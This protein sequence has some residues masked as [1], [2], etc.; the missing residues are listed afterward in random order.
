MDTS[1]SAIYRLQA[2]NTAV[3][4]ENRIHDDETARRFGFR[5]GLVPGVEV[6]AYMAHMPVE[7]FG[8]A[9][10]ERGGMECRFLK[11]VYD[12]HV[13]MVSS[14]ADA[15][16][17]SLRVESDG[18]LCAKGQAWLREPQGARP[19]P[20]AVPGGKPPLE[21]AE[22]SETSLAPGT[23]LAIEPVVID[24]GML[25]QYLSDIREREPLYARAKLV[26]P[27]QILRLANLALLQNVRLGP[28]IHVGSRVENFAPARLHD[29]LS[30]HARIT[31]NYKH[32]GHA[33]VELDAAVLANRNA[34]IAQIRH[35]A[36][37]RPRQIEEA[38]VER[39]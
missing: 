37:W 10:L 31:S 32:K 21:R 2:F 26:H 25:A 8:E 16:G 3:A 20:D 28:W 34:V 11:P 33:M 9:W 12:G 13:A 19:A 29:Q 5:G 36:I 4:S 27:G 6:Y 39:P 1:Q 38:G 23:A 17:L 15:T 18:E 22:A 24:E 14:V 7:R 30:L 35:L